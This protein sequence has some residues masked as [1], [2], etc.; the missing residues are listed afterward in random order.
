M[1]PFNQGLRLVQQLLQMPFLSLQCCIG[2]LQHVALTL[3]TEQ[4][5]FGAVIVSLDVLLVSSSV[6]I[7]LGFAGQ[8]LQG[9]VTVIFVVIMM[10]GGRRTILRPV[11]RHSRRSSGI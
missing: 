11:S 2:I 9:S 1:R 3:Q 5:E 10:I 6:K 8:A 4:R 7:G